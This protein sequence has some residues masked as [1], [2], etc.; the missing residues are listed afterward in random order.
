M[1]RLASASP[2]RKTLLQ[3]AGFKYRYIASSY[4]EIMHSRIPPTRLAQLNAE[5]KVQHIISKSG[6]VLGADTLIAFNGKVIG[7]PKNR[8]QAKRFLASFS[9]KTH[10]V[11]TGVALRDVK[12][13]TLKSFAVVSQVTFRKLNLLEIES[14]LNTNEYIDKAGAYGYQSKG[15]ALVQ[16]VR[17]SRTNV[18]G[19]PMRETKE[20]LKKFG[21]FP[22]KT[23]TKI[24]FK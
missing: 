13:Q 5:G 6:I 8:A 19:L 15:R 7:K 14:Y 11:I 2:R 3:R 1:L 21:I 22:S 24:T 9:G 17:G 10:Q 4:A 20:A 23:K 18:I 16:E 12:R